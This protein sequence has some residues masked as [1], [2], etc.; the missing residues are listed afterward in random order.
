MIYCFIEYH[1][2]ALRILKRIE[3]HFDQFCEQQMTQI[4]DRIAFTY[5]QDDNEDKHDSLQSKRRSH[6]YDHKSV[7]SKKEK[8]TV[9][10]IVYDHIRENR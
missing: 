1:L 8:K 7:R 2:T 3:K 10:V 4:P 9:V 5:S 6:K